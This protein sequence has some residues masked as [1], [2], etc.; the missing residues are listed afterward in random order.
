MYF[1]KLNDFM[2]LVLSKKSFFA[3]QLVSS[4]SF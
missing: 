3:K 1:E 2:Q 4:T